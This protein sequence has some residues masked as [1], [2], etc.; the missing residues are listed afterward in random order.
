V[1]ARGALDEK[2]K[3]IVGLWAAYN[4]ALTI[5]PAKAKNDG[6]MTAVGFKWENGDTNRAV[7]EPL[8]RT[9]LNLWATRAPSRARREKMGT[10]H[11]TTG[12]ASA[13]IARRAL[14]PAEFHMPAVG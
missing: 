12:L 3:D 13:S 10:D 5:A 4:S 7:P 6:T 11:C 9:K 1:A 14:E 2:R 8:R